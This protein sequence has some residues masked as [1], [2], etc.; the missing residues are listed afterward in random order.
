MSIRNFS[1]LVPV[2]TLASLLVSCGVEQ[3]ASSEWWGNDFIAIRK[4]DSFS[5]PRKPLS[6][7]E[8]DLRKRREAI[9]EKERVREAKREAKREGTL[10]ARRAESATAAPA[11]RSARGEITAESP[12]PLLVPEPKKRGGFFSGFTKSRKEE[13][14]GHAIFVNHDLLDTMTPANAR[15]EIS[16]GEQR[17]RLYQRRGRVMQ[18]VVDTA[19]STGKPGHET[20]TGTFKIGEKSVEKKS[21]IYGT[22]LDAAGNPVPGS[23]DVRKRPAGA[24]TF[25]GADM[26][27]WMRINGGIGLHIGEVPGY[28]ASHGCIR[29][30]EA[31]QP[32]IFSRVQ[33]GTPVTVMH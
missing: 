28:P 6:P 21:S 33:V 27:Y 13:Q 14:D 29:V 32:L 26:P 20:P 25:V 9:A 16:L 23:S 10:A 1:H 7:E 3:Q 5:N 24:S 12:E 30:P 2:V 4:P 22:W 17:A 15:L 19:I 31:I 8:Q 18:L 11:S